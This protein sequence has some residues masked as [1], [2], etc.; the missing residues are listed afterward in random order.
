MYIYIY[1]YF[2]NNQSLI[3]HQEVVHIL[4]MLDVP[5]HKHVSELIDGVITE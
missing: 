3:Q 1:I 4:M 2:V 5:L